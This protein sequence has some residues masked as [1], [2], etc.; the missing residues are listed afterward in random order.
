MANAPLYRMI[1]DDLR[2]QI[3]SGRLK[4]GDQL[5]TET[6]LG[7]RYDASRNT[8]RDAI[9]WLTNLGLVETKPGQGT[10][11]TKR[12]VPFV[13]ALV[14]DASTGD[15]E[16]YESEAKQKNRSASLSEVQVEIQRANADPDIVARL[17]LPAGSQIISRHQKR[18]MDDVPWSM[19]TSFYPGDLATRGAELLRD[20]GDIEGGAVKYLRK[21]LNIQQVGYRDMITVRA[22]NPTEAVFFNIPA[23]GRV[24]VFET[25]RTAF[26]EEGNPMRVTVT[27]YP[28][29]RNQ[30]MV[31]VGKVPAH[32]SR[33]GTEDESAEA[34]KASE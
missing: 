29:D 2:Q 11:V 4:P 21:I 16:T 34:L 22:P 27:V 17:G 26:D 10:F 9:R 8:V 25:F 28:T 1:A 18:Y 24:G 31:D 5:L 23:D 7:K 3:E 6:E 20:A 12:G 13:T 19:Q 15:T 14:A 33:P 32:M 30:F